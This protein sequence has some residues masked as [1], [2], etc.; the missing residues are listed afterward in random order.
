VEL[1]SGYICG[2]RSRELKFFGCN[3]SGSFALV[4]EKNCDQFAMLGAI[5]NPAK[6]I[7][8]LNLDTRITS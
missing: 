3:R 6:L 7:Q 4:I 2:S 8:D 1:H 5:N